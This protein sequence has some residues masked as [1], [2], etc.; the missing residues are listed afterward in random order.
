MDLDAFS[1]ECFLTVAETGSFTRS[2][3]RMGRT[4]SAIS[5]QINKLEKLFGKILLT[6]TKP[7]ALTHEGEIFAQFA[8]QI[9]ALQRETMEHFKAPE[10]EGEVRFG[11]PEDFANVFLSE[12]LVSFARVHPK[13]LLKVEC[14]LTVNLFERFKR[15]EFDLVLVKMNCPK[16]FPN[17][18]DVW[19]EKLVWAGNE[20]LLNEL[21]MPLVLSPAP[22]VY[23]NAA[24]GALSAIK[25]KWRVVFLSYSHA[26]K[27]AAV[28]AGLGI[29][30]LPQN[31][32]H[33]KDYIIKNQSKSLPKLIDMT[34]SLLKDTADNPAVNSFERFVLKKLKIS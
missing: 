14:D 1:L 30:V 34:V 13:I 2:A 23:T 28:K 20:A 29:T 7:L 12:V 26:A 22:C 3:E 5:Q 32:V 27:M 19:K 15:N 18:V 31:M 10:L 4:Q 11:I 17:G 8:R 24:F 16:Y 25:K 6:R 9:F 33:P 21:T